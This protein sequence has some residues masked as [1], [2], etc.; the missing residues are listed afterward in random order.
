MPISSIPN[1]SA[2]KQI[3]VIFVRELNAGLERYKDRHAST[4]AVR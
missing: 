4:A 2:G 3:A 1:P